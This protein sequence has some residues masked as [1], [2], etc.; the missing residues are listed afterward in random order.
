M[1]VSLNAIFLYLSQGTYE[2]D[3][4]KNLRRSIRLTSEKF[5]LRGDSLYYGDRRVILTEEE[6]VAVLT[7]VHAGHFGPRRMQ[8]KIAPRFYWRGITQDTLDWVRTCPDCQ[9]FEKLKTEAPQLKPIKPVSPWHMVGVDLFGPMLKSTKGNRYC[10]TLTDYF[11]KWVEARTFAKKTA[12]N[13][14]ETEIAFKELGIEHRV[15]SAYHPQTNGLD[16]RTNQTIK[17][18]IRKTIRGQRERWEDNLREIVYAN[19]TCVQASTRYSPFRLMFGREARLF[20]ELTSD[21]PEVRVAS[22]DPDEDSVEAFVQLRG[23]QDEKV[24]GKEQQKLAYRR[25]MKRGIKRFIITPGMEVLKKDERK[26][27]RPGRTMDPNW[28][29]TSYR[30]TEVQPNNIVQ[31]ETLDGKPLRMKTPYASVKPLRQRTRPGWPTESTSESVLL[32]D[33]EMCSS[34]LEEELLESEEEMEHAGTKILGPISA[35]GLGVV[36]VVKYAPSPGRVSWPES[37]K[38]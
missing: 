21:C 23:G 15:S 30:V 11:T 26:K 25:K 7:E 36:S 18:S 8:E 35:C 31:L 32:G 3:V 27:G 5:C 29:Q 1:V 16:E 12:A 17:V 14:K 33:A 10:L 28:S 6:K 13:V 24:L 19:N 20:T 22:L 37:R 2:K 4:C 9:C 34:E 38:P